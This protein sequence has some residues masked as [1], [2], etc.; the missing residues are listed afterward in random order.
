MPQ[1]PRPL[2]DHRFASVP[3]SSQKSKECLWIHD[4]LLRGARPP[5]FH[6]F[7]WHNLNVQCELQSCGLEGIVPSLVGLCE[8]HK[9]ITAL[10]NEKLKYLQDIRNLFAGWNGNVAHPRQSLWHAAYFLQNTRTL[11]TY[12]V[13]DYHYHHN[14]SIR[15]GQRSIYQT[16]SVCCNLKHYTNISVLKSVNFALFHS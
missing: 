12:G 16:D 6:C 7:M 11:G 1:D 9:S 15:E 8:L 14:F 4:F 13:F 10:L 3:D 5:I 2:G